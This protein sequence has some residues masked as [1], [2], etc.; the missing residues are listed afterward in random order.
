MD[1][2]DPTR[3]ELID[4]LPREIPTKE[5]VGRRFYLMLNKQHPNLSTLTEVNDWSDYTIVFP[6]GSD[7][8]FHKIPMLNTI[9]LH[10][11]PLTKQFDI[12]FL[13]NVD[14]IEV[15]SLTQHILTELRNG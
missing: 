3:T 1:L 5:I 15:R 6:K 8:A 9:D 4:S 12:T 7:I 10:Y 2:L 13:D 14:Y 11:H